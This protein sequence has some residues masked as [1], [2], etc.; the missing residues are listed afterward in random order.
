MKRGEITGRIGVPL[1]PNILMGIGVI[2][3]EIPSLQPSTAAGERDAT[4]RLWYTLG[5][6]RMTYSEG[7]LRLRRRPM[8]AGRFGLEVEQSLRNHDKSFYEKQ[9]EPWRHLLRATTT[10]RDDVLGSPENWTLSSGYINGDGH[11]ISEL[12]RKETAELNAGLLKILV[13]GKHIERSVPK[14][15]ISSDWGILEAVQQLSDSEDIRY[16]FAMLEGLSVI[17][18]NQRLSYRGNL[19]FE[20]ESGTV[21]LHRYQLLGRGI[22]PREYWLNESGELWFVTSADR[23]LIREEWMAQPLKELHR[24]DFEQGVQI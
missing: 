6:T 12:Y 19:E 4:F 21:L 17:K 8:N 22:I 20:T 13:N 14:G 24:K 2:K 18:E 3:A 9:H 16:D 5:L 11:P 1:D 10:C 23:A 15:P 7:F